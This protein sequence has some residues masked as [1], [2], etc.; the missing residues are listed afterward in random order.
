MT[1]LV[2]HSWHYLRHISAA[3]V[4]LH[5]RARFILHSERIVRG[6]QVTRQWRLV[7]RLSS[8]TRGRSIPDLERE[9]EVTSRT[10]RRDLAALEHAGFPLISETRGG[11]VFWRFIDGY[12]PESPV[13]FTT[14]E[15]M[16]LHFSRRL[17]EPLKGTPMY[18]GI[19]SALQ[20]IGAVVSLRVP[21][22]RSSLDSGISV[23]SFGRKDYRK[24]GDIL[25]KLMRGMRNHFTLEFEYKPP[26][27]EQA[28]HYRL[29]L[30]TLWYQDHGLYVVGWDHDH[31]EYRVFAVE[32]IGAVKATNQRFEPR[33][34]FNFHVLKNTAFRFIWGE[35]KQVRIRF[36][37]DQA[38]Y[39][40]ERMWHVSQKVFKQEDGSVVLQFNVAD[41]VEVKRWLIGWGAAAE[42]VE[43]QELADKI[44]EECQY[45]VTQSTSS[46]TLRRG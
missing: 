31:V 44:V 12:Q 22:L 6:D 45:I 19:Q 24:S 23:S 41:L 27:R 11:E 39:A 35:P 25:A 4:F 46:T 30:Y 17:L 42:V 2:I 5:T 14:D 36:S 3:Y 43:P 1:A 20:K 16:A 10:V 28:G 7:R 21:S 29:D 32:R 33:G 26:K 38:A 13:A 37:P 9:L 8:T 18:E 34:D 40:T 15:L